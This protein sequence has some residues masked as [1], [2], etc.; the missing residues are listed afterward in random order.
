M[1]TL[2]RT[3]ARKLWNQYWQDM[4]QEWFKIEV[5]QDYTGE[6]DGPSLRAWLAGDKQRSLVLLKQTTHNDW[7]E[8]C[9]EKYNA[10]VLMR[11]IRVIEKPY[12]AY[13]EWE[14]EF[15][16]HVN[17][18]GGE[19]IFIV[20]KRDIAN[21]DLPSGDL[22]MFDNKRAAV[23]VYDET[24]RVIRQTFYDESDNITKFL[25]FKHDLLP[26]AQSLQA[27]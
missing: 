12:T 11:R 23:C 8:M 5:L 20:N 21:L 3:E 14:I 17:I 26:L 10:G 9:Q 25:R 4:K 27:Q 6:D 1:K 7:R 18:L 19:Q 16:K 13:T 2:D 24:G 22:M 15:Y